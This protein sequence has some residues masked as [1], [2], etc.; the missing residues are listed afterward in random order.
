M[1]SNG[2]PIKNNFTSKINVNNNSIE[3]VKEIILNSQPL[4]DTITEFKT[5]DDEILLRIQLLENFKVL[6]TTQ[7]NTMS[8]RL[9]Y[10]E[11]QNL[12]LKT[13]IFDLTNIV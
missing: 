5:L 7:M 12:R 13:I 1:D 8:A 10:L 6:T 2:R 9:S 11:I 3:G 4:T